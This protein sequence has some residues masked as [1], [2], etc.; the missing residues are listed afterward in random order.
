MR[1]P[2]DLDVQDPPVVA[3][4]PDVEIAHPPVGV[5]APYLQDWRRQAMTPAEACEVEL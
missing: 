4:K 5:A 3:T 2:I 1:G